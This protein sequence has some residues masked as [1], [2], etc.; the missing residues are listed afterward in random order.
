[1]RRYLFALAFAGA[2]LAG[3]TYYQTAPGTV[4][5]TPASNFDRSWAAVIGA[6]QDQGVQITSEDRGAGIVRGTRNGINVTASVRTQADGS[7]RV[8]FNTAG[9]T[10][11]DPALIDR[12][13][14]SYDRRMGR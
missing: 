7:V 2:L 1:M 11:R 12:I 5:T 3:C 9:A 10:E 4:V 14:Q 6:L 13:S 8:E